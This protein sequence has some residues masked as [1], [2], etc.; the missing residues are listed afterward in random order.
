MSGDDDR[1]CNQ[2]IPSYSST[3]CPGCEWRSRLA[4]LARLCLLCL[5]AGRVLGHDRAAI[6]HALRRAD[7]SLTRLLHRC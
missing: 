7:A 4:A 6:S 5:G 2:W 3:Q 1:Y